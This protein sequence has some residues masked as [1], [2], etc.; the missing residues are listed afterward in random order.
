MIDKEHQDVAQDE[1]NSNVG[2]WAGTLHLLD[3]L[4]V[5][6]ILFRGMHTRVAFLVA[7]GGIVVATLL[8]H[9]RLLLLHLVL[10]GPILFD[11]LL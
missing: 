2:V 6:L 7:F 4:V 1:C 9:V 8:R 5:V 3:V 10:V 11:L